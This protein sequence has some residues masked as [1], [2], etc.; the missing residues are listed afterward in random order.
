MVDNFLKFT[1]FGPKLLVAR[2]E[3]GFALSGGNCSTGLGF[4]QKSTSSIDFPQEFQE[5]RQ[6]SEI[7]AFPPPNCSWLVLRAVL[8]F[9]GAIAPRGSDFYKNPPPQSI[10]HKKSKTVDSFPKFTR[11]R[12]QIARGSF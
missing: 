7:H 4:L 12:P 1:R 10:F 5:G 8:R 2:F 11:F 6:F 9:Q 3:G